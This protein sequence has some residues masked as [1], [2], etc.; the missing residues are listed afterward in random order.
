[1]P[2]RSNPGVSRTLSG[3]AELPFLSQLSWPASPRGARQAS[4]PIRSRKRNGDA[5]LTELSDSDSDAPRPKKPRLDPLQNRPLLESNRNLP[6]YTATEPTIVVPNPPVMMAPMGSLGSGAAQPVPIQVPFLPQGPVRSINEVLNE[7]SRVV[8]TMHQLRGFL[9]TRPD[10]DKDVASDHINACQQR[11]SA[12]DN[13]IAEMQ[14]TAA[15]ERLVVPPNP[16]PPFLVP[17]SIRASVTPELAPSGTMDEQYPGYTESEDEMGNAK[18]DQKSGF[19][20]LP[21][22]KHSISTARSASRPAEYVSPPDV[23]STPSLCL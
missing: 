7:R 2:Q 11:L 19:L 22:P 4:I 13:Q 10:I 15:P 20:S 3:P 23:P 8:S 1:V 17:T 9:N 5:A 16:H 6:T 18:N 21:M 12:I 14:M